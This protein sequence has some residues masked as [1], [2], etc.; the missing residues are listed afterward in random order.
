M[1]NVLVQEETLTHIAD[2]IREKSGNTASY[3]P[4][5]MPEAI[6]DISTY[7]GEGADPNKPIRFY[8]PYGE[9][10]YSYSLVE[11]S[12]LKELPELP[13]YRGLVGQE[14]NWSLEKIKEVEG[15]VEIGSLYTTDDGAT[16]IYVN[17]ITGALNPKI[18]FNQ[19]AADSVW[20]DWGDGSP[21]ETSDIYGTGTVVSIEHQY[22]RAGNYIIRLIPKENAEI[23]F[24]GNSYSTLILHKNT[25]HDY[26]NRVYGNAIRKIELGKGVTKFTNRCFNSLTL[27]NVTIPKEITAFGTAFQGCTN[28][29]CITVPKAVKSLAS[30]SLRDCTILE[31]ILFSETAISLGGTSLA[32]NNN[33]RE[34][35]LASNV[36]L[37]YS[38]IFTECQ[39]LQRVVLPKGLLKLGTDL[40]TDC[41]ALREVKLPSSLTSIGNGVFGHC[42]NLEF[43]EIPETVTS[44]QGTAFYYCHALR[45]LELPPKITSIQ[46]NLFT[47]CYSLNE[48]TVPKNVTEIQNSAFYNC[49]SIEHYYMLPET[50]P[51][52]VNANA[53]YGIKDSCMIHVP[54]GCLEAYQIAAVWSEFA[55]YMVEME[56]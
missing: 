38:S 36:N 31:K 29:K 43:V 30:Y 16:R 12:E 40:F 28:L 17:L 3:K 52:L 25:E 54:K 56:E 13:E 53:F 20:I 15:E 10:I 1:G 5:E 47:N 51:T 26:G 45:K 2:A 35:I 46:A 9:L 4:R 33:L 42:K 44:I 6:L 22:K 48:M 27:E 21:M 7:S 50:P 8:N 41:L 32:N 24:Q 14:W 49:L 34:I 23:T 39:S 37:S 19:A 55:D 11:I 18:G